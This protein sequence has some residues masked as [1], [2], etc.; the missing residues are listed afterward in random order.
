[1]AAFSIDCVHWDTMSELAHCRLLAEYNGWMN[2]KLY[3]AAA[4][5]T[6]AELNADRG[7]FFG[8]L[9]GT[10]NHLV[11]GDTIWLSRFAGHPSQ[12]T[13]L[14]P[15]RAMAA[16]TAVTAI[17][18]TELALLRAR[19]EVLDGAILALAAQLNQG[20]LD[21]A[22]RYANTKGV[23]SQR[24]FGS[25]LM[26]FFNHQTHHRG[27]ASTLLSQAGV[28]IGVTDLLML[29]PDEARA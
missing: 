4:R 28:D 12:H 20:D 21:H 13:A 19:R 29:V 8:S 15:V 9:I 17:H 3:D 7:A 10:M 26:H 6:A 5:L 25:L 14:D 16:P 2:T 1:M 11:A 18:S 23:V 22:L 24:R 27:Q